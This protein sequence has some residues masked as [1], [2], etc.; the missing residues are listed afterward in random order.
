M[1]R[2]R[3]ERTSRPAKSAEAKPVSEDGD[4]PSVSEATPQEQEAEA[5]AKAAGKASKRGKPKPKTDFSQL[6]LRLEA[7][8]FASNQALGTRRLSK[9]LEVSSED[10][11]KGLEAL[12]RA[13]AERK[14]ALELVEVS[15]GWR[16][17]TRAAYH[18]DVAKLTAKAKVEKLS[19]AA[20]ET[21]AVVA[22]RQPLGRAD[23]EAVRGV[24]CG[25]LLRVLLD[26]DLIRIAGR[27]SEPG[28]PLLY[29]TSKRFLDHFGLASLKNLPDV[30]DL[31]NAS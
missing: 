26:R 2:K 22:Y 13:W 20:L 30:K 17:L 23:I 9:A 1:I 11:K 10:V 16:L 12:E 8:L 6:A 25:P 5:P 7:L 28:H 3:S 18:G 15:G 27:S 24:Q 4:E 14:S 29:G 31:L 21:L 19:S